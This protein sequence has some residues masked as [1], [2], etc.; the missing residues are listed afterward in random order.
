MT[1]SSGR[2]SPPTPG[3]GRVDGTYSGGTT[4]A[5][6]A[7]SAGANT[8]LGLNGTSAYAYTDAV[9]AA[10]AD[11]TVETWLRT[12]TTRGGRIVGF[13][14]GNMRQS[15]TTDRQALHAQ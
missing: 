15:T 10:P 7:L 8:A 12:T 1:T 14:Q 13:S 6:G 4:R 9:R 3:S 11:V 2:P 5:A